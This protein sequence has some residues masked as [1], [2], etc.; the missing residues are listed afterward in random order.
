MGGWS[1]LDHKATLWQHLAS[2]NFPLLSLA[3]NPRWSRGWQL[4]TG[5]HLCILPPI[6]RNSFKDLMSSLNE[7]QLSLAYPSLAQMCP[8]LFTIKNK[9]GIQLGLVVFV[10]MYIYE[11]LNGL[12]QCMCS[13]LTVIFRE[14]YECNKTKQNSSYCTWC[15]IIKFTF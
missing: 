1:K 2:W 7:F 6:I 9:I 14:F 10:H 15:P 11:S 3:E 12:P 4:L 8:S 13:L 5:F